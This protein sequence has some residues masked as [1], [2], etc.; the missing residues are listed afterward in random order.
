MTAEKTT[1]KNNGIKLV[2]GFLGGSGS[3]H[4][5]CPQLMNPIFKKHI[6]KDKTYHKYTCYQEIK[7][8]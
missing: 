3:A 8:C 6:Q 1:T 7:I 2:I 4:L 5:K